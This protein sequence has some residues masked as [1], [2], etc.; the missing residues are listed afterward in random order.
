MIYKISNFLHYLSQD[1]LGGP[2]LFK[3]SALINF[4]KGGT[5]PFV[6]FLMY[7]FENYSINAWVYLGMHG[8]YGLCWLI[9]HAYFP[10]KRWDVAITIGGAAMSFVLLLG[11]YWLFPIILIGPWFHTVPSDWSGPFL[12]GCIFL[13]TLGVAIMM[14]SDAQKYYTLKYKP[15][16]IREGLFSR[17]RNPNYLGEMMIYGSYA[18]MARH[19][20]AWMILA[21][22]WLGYFTINMIIKDRSLST[23]AGWAEYKKK[24]SILFPKIN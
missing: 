22:V 9:K 10:D 18:L 21:W 19:W 4:Q 3:L 23:K 2:R 12:G 1:F 24:S 13:H 8:S 6:L 16:L 7:Y 14:A 15:G 17:T 5:L 11:L 20:L